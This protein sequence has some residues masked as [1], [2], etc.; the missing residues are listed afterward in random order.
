M[1][2]IFN[3]VMRIVSSLLGVLMAVGGTFWALQ[4]LHLTGP[5]DKSFMVGDRH[6]VLYG[7][8]F[9]IVGLCQVIWSNIR[10]RS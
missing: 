9:A 8:I 1:R 5:N 7:A 10:Q 3:I 6:W 4:G 2:A